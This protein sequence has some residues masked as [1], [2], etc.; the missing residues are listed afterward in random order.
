PIYRNVWALL[1]EFGDAE[2]F[3][4]ITPRSVWVMVSAVPPIE[5]PP[6]P[7][8]GRGG[9]APGGL[10]TPKAEDVDREW[11]RGLELCRPLKRDKANLFLIPQSA[12]AADYLHHYLFD[13]AKL[14]PKQIKI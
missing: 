5:G 11:K 12:T 8:D 4:L 10:Q 6:S 14:D 3:Q 7:R 1:S 2:L 13:L 9:A